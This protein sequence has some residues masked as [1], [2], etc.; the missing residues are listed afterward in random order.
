[1]SSTAGNDT[2]TVSAM[3]PWNYNS[4]AST[5]VAS[6]EPSSLGRV[7]T[8]SC[9]EVGTSTERKR[10]K[11]K[12]QKSKVDNFAKEK[13][14]EVDVKDKIS[15]I[16]ALENKRRDSADLRNEDYKN[17]KQKAFKMNGE[18]EVIVS[19]ADSMPHSEDISENINSLKQSE[20]YLLKK[21]ECCNSSKDEISKDLIRSSKTEL[22]GACNSKLGL[23]KKQHRRSHKSFGFLR[24]EMLP[25]TLTFTES[26]LLDVVDKVENMVMTDDRE[27][28]KR[29]CDQ[30]EDKES[31][32]DDCKNLCRKKPKC[33]RFMEVSLSGS[34]KSPPEPPDPL[35][36]TEFPTTAPTLP[37]SNK[38]SNKDA[39]PDSLPGF[40]S[41]DEEIVGFGLAE[42]FVSDSLTS[43]GLDKG[44]CSV[45][46][47]VFSLELVVSDC[48]V[49]SPEG[50]AIEHSENVFP[51]SSQ[52]QENMEN[53]L[54]RFNS[55]SLENA[56]HQNSGNSPVG[57]VASNLVLNKSAVSSAGCITSQA[58]HSGIA[59]LAKQVAP[60]KPHGSLGTGVQPKP[61]ALKSMVKVS[62][63][64]VRT[65]IDTVLVSNNQTQANC[66][67][68][69]NENIFSNKD[70]YLPSSKDLGLDFAL[71]LDSKDKALPSDVTSAYD[72]VL[73]DPEPQTLMSL[74]FSPPNETV[75]QRSF[76]LLNEPKVTSSKPSLSSSDA[77]LIESSVQ[78]SVNQVAEI[79]TTTSCHNMPSSCSSTYYNTS[80]QTST[81]CPTLPLQTTVDMRQSPTSSNLQ[82]TATF[83][84]ASADTASNHPRNSTV[85]P[86]GKASSCTVTT[87]NHSE[88]LMSSNY[89]IRSSANLSHSTA[90]VTSS[91]TYSSS[92]NQ[93]INSM[94]TSVTCTTTSVKMAVASGSSSSRSS[95]SQKSLEGNIRSSALPHE[96][97]TS[98]SMYRSIQASERTERHSCSKDGSL[99]PNSDYFDSSSQLSTSSSCAVQG[100]SLDGTFHYPLPPYLLNSSRDY[101]QVEGCLSRY[102][103]GN[104]G[105]LSGS[106][107]C[108]DYNALARYSVYFSTP[109][110]HDLGL[111]VASH[112]RISLSPNQNLPSCSIEK[113]SSASKVSLNN[114]RLDG[115]NT[116]SCQSR[117]QDDRFPCFPRS[118]H[119][120]DIAQCGN[121]Q[122]LE[123]Q[124]GVSHGLVAH[125]HDSNSL[126]R[127]NQRLTGNSGIQ[128]NCSRSHTSMT[129][130]AN[131]RLIAFPLHS[132]Y[133][134]TS[135]A[136]SLASP[137]LHH[138]SMTSDRH[139]LSQQLG[140]DLM[141]HN[142][143]IQ[144]FSPNLTGVGFDPPPLNF[145]RD[146]VNNTS[147]HAQSKKVG[148]KIDDHTSSAGSKMILSHSKQSQSST[149]Q[150]E[151]SSKSASSSGRSTR[152]SKKSG[153]SSSYD[154]DSGLYEG[155]SVTPYVGL[156]NMSPNFPPDSLAYMNFFGNASRPLSNAVKTLQHRDPPAPISHPFNSS[157]F[158]SS[159]AQ[160]GLGINF[161][162]GFGMDH[163]NS[164]HITSSQMI[165]P[166]SSAISA[167]MHGFGFFPDISSSMVQRDALNNMPSMKFGR[168][169]I[170]SSQETAEP[171]PLQHPQT[172]SNAMYTIRG[173][174]P[175]S[176][177]LHDMSFNT[178]L[179]HQHAAFDAR[180]I[181]S[182][183]V[184]PPFGSHNHGPSFGMGHLNFPVHNL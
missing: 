56:I 184:H 103:S 112:Q 138:H 151:Q 129:S 72:W 62:Q 83:G 174:L 84:S 132:G 93:K 120:H 88:I 104:Y 53:A 78:C 96:R 15:L 135:V 177:M 87:L 156:G 91:V 29:S 22:H 80:S 173:Q 131:D 31:R 145:S 17:L 154:M 28:K 32:S 181:G 51:E 37:G 105:M 16:G 40:E 54:S 162:T 61:I 45:E 27:M 113:N 20:E 24:P 126:S 92:L 106:S 59:S 130:P 43:Q 33:E 165:I 49:R 41:E 52:N 111:D 64:T 89:P 172:V 98:A 23:T 123:P 19:F 97:T 118:S 76:E 171:G 150:S 73:G 26:E 13:K 57:D 142:P 82:M 148:K 94:S 60:S 35:P 155:R 160:N 179:G 161:Q 122:F 5:V 90:T 133:S 36:W 127:S 146:C 38:D 81:D 85:P 159:R 18:N 137:P 10:K 115:N 107:C 34:C 71:D 144:T 170:L 12:R 166:H 157:L 182:G 152:S 65:E 136:S 175:P 110:T 6:K 139:C 99:R 102:S 4:E 124:G 7:E 42:G 119:M 100:R 30:I 176:H 14:V 48:I 183:M 158:S 44:S 180:S 149:I 46:S 153:K 69:Y 86:L 2:V 77:L 164:S 3:V 74:D 55:Q 63:G 134:G 109:F 75:S 101:A 9:R 25:D 11:H 114:N 1:M 95:C 67:D 79:Q 117:H 108:G 147:P 121:S 163:V 168:G 47:P 66:R 140:Y 8:T 167:H 125:N 39:V 178:L 58:R 169:P 21:Q 70:H 116:K 68:T 143:T 50:A 141:F 128:N